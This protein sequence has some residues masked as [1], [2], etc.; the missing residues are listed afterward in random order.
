[1]DDLLPMARHARDIGFWKLEATALAVGTTIHST[2]VTK[3]RHRGRIGTSS[4]MRSIRPLLTDLPDLDVHSSCRPSS[5][6]M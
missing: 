1:M 3:F 6:R 2:I 5:L 4:L